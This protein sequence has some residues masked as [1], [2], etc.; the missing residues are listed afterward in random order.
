ML[1]HSCV[2]SNKCEAYGNEPKYRKYRINKAIRI[3]HSK[4]ETIQ[5][6]RLNDLMV[7]RSDSLSL[8]KELLQI[9]GIKIQGKTFSINAKMKRFQKY[10]C[11]LKIK[12]IYRKGNQ[13]FD[14]DRKFKLKVANSL[15]SLTS[16]N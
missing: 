14:I 16:K 10:K 9:H 1:F 2:T 6:L 5:N 7:N 3:E 11:K 8:K 15:K 13:E 12:T 4:N